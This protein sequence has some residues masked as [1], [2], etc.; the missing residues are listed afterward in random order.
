VWLERVAEDKAA[1]GLSEE[2]L[3]EFTRRVS[4][5]IGI[6]APIYGKQILYDGKT[7]EPFDQ[8]VTVGIIHMLKLAHLVEDKVHAR[9]TG[10]YSLVTQQPLGGKAQFGGHFGEM[11]VW[12]GGTARRIRSGNAD[13]QIGRCRAARQDLRSHRQGEGGSRAS[14]VSACW[15]E[16]QSLG[17]AVE[18]IT[19]TGEVIKFGKEGNPLGPRCQWGCWGLLATA[20]S[21][22]RDGLQS[23][24]SE[25]SPALLF[26]CKVLRLSAGGLALTAR[27]P[28]C[29]GSGTNCNEVIR[30]ISIYYP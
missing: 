12:A 13:R 20:K 1:E 23:G 14:A 5:K 29:T 27:R 24:Q 4:L 7:G 3:R 6:Q 25:R 19:D 9:S 26:R 11:E 10:P 2:E 22:L 17:L 30:T 21:P 28:R 18:A 16:L 15:S 8:T